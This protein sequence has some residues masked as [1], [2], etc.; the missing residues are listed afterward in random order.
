MQSKKIMALLLVTAVMLVLIPLGLSVTARNMKIIF[1][2]LTMPDADYPP[3]FFSE[4]LANFKSD[5]KWGFID[6]TG[7]II[8]P[9]EFDF[10]EP[11]SEG[12]ARFRQN[13]SFKNGYIDKTG[14]VVIP[15]VYND[16]YAFSEERALVSITESIEITEDGGMSVISKY[17][18]IDKTGNVVIPIEYG[19]ARSFSEGLAA[20]S[21]N[22]GYGFIDRNGDVVIPFQYMY[23][24]SFSGGYATVLIDWEPYHINN[25]GEVIG[26][27]RYYPDDAVIP[28]EYD[29]VYPFYEGM[30][31]VHNRDIVDYGDYI[32][33][34]NEKYGFINTNGE[35]IVPVIYDSVESFSNGFA[36]V[37]IGKRWVD[38]KY[39]YID[40]TGRVV[41]PIEY[42]EAISFSEGL[43]VVKKDGQW[44]ILTIAGMYPDLTCDIN[45]DDMI[46]IHDLA[47][48]LN[49]DNFNKNTE[50]AG[51]DF[52]CD[53]N[54]DGYIDIDDLIM[55]LDSANY[56]ELID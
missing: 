19:Y 22:E 54:E 45:E 5:G 3:W 40:Q 14:V 17:G 52:R 25:K 15:A 24:L 21:T 36:V 39:G 27:G 53:I 18:F 33:Y 30:A 43:A 13:D 50:A 44:S 7:K 11:F 10:V 56:N 32:R 28:T 6:R 48:L 41:V 4:G 47:M 35:L 49:A 31:I 20:V 16:A 8:I 37:G 34:E 1:T 29:S 51:V 38:R 46:D 23:A 55:L 2:P 42:D 26:A 9:F 12:L